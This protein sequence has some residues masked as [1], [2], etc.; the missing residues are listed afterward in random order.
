MQQVPDAAL[1]R[2]HTH[3]CRLTLGKCQELRQKMTGPH[4]IVHLAHSTPVH[5][6]VDRLHLLTP[7]INMLISLPAHTCTNLPTTTAS[8]ECWLAV[9]MPGNAH[10]SGTDGSL[11]HSA[12]IV[13]CTNQL[14]LSSCY[15]IRTTRQQTSWQ[16]KE[17]T[18]HIQRWALHA[19]PP[20]ASLQ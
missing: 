1:C 7:C 13:K 18:P 16:H 11:E 14:L 6:T 4:S 15:R 2:R 5:Q 12:E 10:A 19:S 8:S 3:V 9:P 17:A 20:Q